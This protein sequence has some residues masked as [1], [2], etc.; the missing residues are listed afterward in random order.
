MENKFIELFGEILEKEVST[1]KL[2]DAF[3]DYDEWDSLANLSVIAMLD[4]EYEVHIE[5]KDFKN[6]ITVGDLINEVQKRIK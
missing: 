2:E 1:I 6:L 5:S 3:R 4:D